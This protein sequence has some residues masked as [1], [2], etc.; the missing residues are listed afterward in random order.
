MARGESGRIVIEVNPDIKNELYQ[1]LECEKSN[2]KTWFLGQVEAY[3]DTDNQ[4]SLELDS[5]T[6]STCK[7][8]KQ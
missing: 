4:L 2:L 1:K 6:V 5:E 7:N 8:N 3:L